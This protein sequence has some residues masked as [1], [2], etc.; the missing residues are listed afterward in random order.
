MKTKICSK[1]KIEKGVCEFHKRSKNLDGYNHEC[2][3]CRKTETSLY[4][5]K[6]KNKIKENVSKYREENPEKV[7]VSRK[8]SYIKNNDYYKLKSKLYREQNKEKR[9]TYT[10]HRKKIDPIFKLKHLMGSR[11]L[12]FLKSKNITKNNKTFNII[13]CSPEY[14]KEYLEKQFTEN[15]SWDLIGKHI[16]IDH[17]IPLCSAKTEEEI[18]KLCHYT[19]LQPMWALDN[20]RKGGKY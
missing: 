17:I 5:T 1:C 14:L 19:N 13:G 12:I 9:N 2:K 11:L 3:I 10:N 20:I 6:Y 18:Y 8:N 15:M 4:Y 7:K 16:H